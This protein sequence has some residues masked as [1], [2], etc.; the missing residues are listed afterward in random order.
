MTKSTDLFS[1]LC[2]IFL[3]VVIGFLIPIMCRRNTV[4]NFYGKKENCGKQIHKMSK[5][6]SRISRRALK[7]QAKF[8]SRINKCSSKKT[9]IKE[10]LNACKTDLSQ[11]HDS[12]ATCRQNK[13][14]LEQTLKAKLEKKQTE[15]REQRVQNR[16]LVTEK[17][18]CDMLVQQ[19]EEE[20]KDLADR[21]KNNRSGVYT[22]D[23]M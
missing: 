20:C 9:K 16:R 14:N 19:K 8:T 7:K 23:A 17:Q 15:L 21:V 12:T 5:K 10:R 13:R 3:I 2:I 11:S 4:E 22:A 18:V 1:D 6:L